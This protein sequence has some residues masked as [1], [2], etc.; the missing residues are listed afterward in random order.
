MSPVM[1]ALMILK[2]FFALAV[3]LIIAI[4][5]VRFGLPRILR[6]RSSGRRHI[7][8][9]EVYPLDRQT[10][11]ILFRVRD[12]FYLCA[13]SPEGM[14]RIDRW[15]RKRSKSIRVLKEDGEA[16]FKRYL[17]ASQHKEAP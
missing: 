12:R 10:R 11:L 7:R 17:K 2:V 6:I 1:D 8:V 9:L 3:V 5:V 4:L 14:V 13:A 15:R 16:E